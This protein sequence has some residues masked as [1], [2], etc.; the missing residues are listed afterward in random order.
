[1]SDLVGTTL[2]DQYFL[3]RIVGSGGSA[4][5]YL[6]WDRKRSTHMAVKI[7]RQDLSNDERLIK[8]FEKEAAL[9]NK[10]QHPN[11]V[12]LYEFD[13]QGQIIFFVM[14]WVKGSDLKKSIL[15]KQGPFP[16]NEVD[17]I[18]APISIALE[19]AHKEK[20]FHCDVKPANILL[21]EDGKVLLSDFGVARHVFEQKQGGGTPPYMAPEQFTG[22]NIDARTDVYGLGVILYEMLSGGKVPFRGE[23]PQSPGKTTREKIEWEHLNLPLA[24][25]SQH[26]PAL[27]LDVEAVV[28]KALNKDPTFRYPSVVALKE[29]FENACRTGKQPDQPAKQTDHSRDTI[30]KP[31]PP[32]VPNQPTSDMR[33]HIRDLTAEK[34]HGPHLFGRTGEYAGRFILLSEAT[35]TLGRGKTSLVHLQDPHVSRSH[36]TFFKTR[37]GMYVRDENSS[38]GTFVNGRR[39]L[40]AQSVLLRHGDIIR[41]GFSEE[42]EYKEK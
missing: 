20:I 29:A 40:P 5:V 39:I 34:I 18:L 21:D 2:K 19:Y 26:N 1:M 38:L 12:R 27:P 32:P 33:Q 13:K 28:T 30:M 22:G 9:L 17:R 8:M 25:L 41:V 37:H 35:T 14:D 3:T 42:L 31:G 24:P 23:S 4:D 7:M 10:L 36:A 16:L 6:A 11:I 15:E